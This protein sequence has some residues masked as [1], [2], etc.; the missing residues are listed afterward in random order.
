[1][2]TISRSPSTFESGS[3]DRLNV[4]L[5]DRY[6][7]CHGTIEEKPA[8]GAFESL[9]ATELLGWLQRWAGLKHHGRLARETLFL[10]DVVRD[11]RYRP[12]PR[13]RLR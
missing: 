1:M 12:R 9:I 5:P 6:E 7:V 4:E 10:L 3:V 8:M 11:L 13:V 2:A